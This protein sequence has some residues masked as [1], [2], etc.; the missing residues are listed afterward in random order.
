MYF[1]AMASA[2]M[3]LVLFVVGTHDGHRLMV[4]HGYNRGVG[5]VHTIGKAH[6]ARRNGQAHAI[7]GCLGFY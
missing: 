6:E 2:S 4:S 7:V 3:V 1:L 5:Y